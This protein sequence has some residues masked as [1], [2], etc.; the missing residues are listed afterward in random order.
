[1]TFADGFWFGLGLVAAGITV[2]VPVLVLAA[3]FARAGRET[4][5]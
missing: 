5:P 1:M 3:I 4:A 2:T